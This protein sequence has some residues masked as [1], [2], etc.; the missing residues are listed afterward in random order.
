MILL[1]DVFADYGQHFGRTPFETGAVPKQGVVLEQQL[2][3]GLWTQW[4][5]DTRPT[6]DFAYVLDTA[7]IVVEQLL[8]LDDALL[9]VNSLAAGE[10]PVAGAL[11]GALDDQA[12]G[13]LSEGLGGAS[14]G[15]ILRFAFRQLWTDHFVDWVEKEQDLAGTADPDR[16]RTADLYAVFN[17]MASKTKREQI[18]AALGSVLEVTEENAGPLYDAYQGFAFAWV[19]RDH[20][21]SVRGW[22]LPNAAEEDRGAFGRIIT[23]LAGPGIDGITLGDIGL[24]RDWLEGARSARIDNLREQLEPD[25]DFPAP[26]DGHIPGDLPGLDEVKPPIGT[27]DSGSSLPQGPISSSTRPRGRATA[28]RSRR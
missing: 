4:W 23:A 22:M 17:W 14:P 28:R 5:N 6:L 20:P 9:A 3:N 2:A 27:A 21:L 11:R 25:W 1:G 26:N 10:G 8:H 16:I 18:D 24:I 13:S 15:A 19:Y 7:G 12:V